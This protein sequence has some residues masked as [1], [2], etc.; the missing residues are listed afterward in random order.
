MCT[1]CPRYLQADFFLLGLCFSLNGYSNLR[2]FLYI[3]SQKND[4]KCC[5]FNYNPVDSNSGVTAIHYWGQELAITTKL[6]ERVTT[7][8]YL[9]EHFLLSF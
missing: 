3:L 1:R 2:D 8:L 5:Y 9:C 6:S 4:L 7:E